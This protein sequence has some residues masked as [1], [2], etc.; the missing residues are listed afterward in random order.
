LKNLANQACQGDE[1][2][3]LRKR[4]IPGFQPKHLVGLTKVIVE[5]TQDFVDHLERLAQT[6]EEFG[7]DELTT[8]LAFDITGK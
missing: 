6:G 7:V 5:K 8:N 2:K 4:I 1:W 3:N